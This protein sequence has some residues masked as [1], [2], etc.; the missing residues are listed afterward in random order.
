[1]DKILNEEIIQYI[2][3]EIFPLYNRNE[4]GHGI[5]HIETVIRRSL[6]LATKYDVN[7]DMVY[8]IAAYHDLG[9]GIDRKNS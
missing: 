5:K 4:E 9:H 7:L 2:N 1:M 6:E 8:V 3:S